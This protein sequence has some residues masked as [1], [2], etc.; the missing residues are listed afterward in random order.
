M[1]AAKNEIV[2]AAKQL[3]M[4]GRKFYIEAGS[5]ASNEITAEVFRHLAQDEEDH[6]KWIEK[7]FPEGGSAEDINRKLYSDLEPIFANVPEEVR[8]QIKDAE[9]DIS[10]MKFAMEMEDKAQRAYGK[11]A[12]ES[13]SDDVRE[14]CLTLVK[15]ERFHRQ[16]LENMVQYLDRP[17]DWFQQQENWMFDGG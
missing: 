4:D 7:M 15:V 10:A 5:N 3:E 9:D 8:K 11:W 16:L 1:G 13:D 17:D 2:Q 12:E 6:L 14:L